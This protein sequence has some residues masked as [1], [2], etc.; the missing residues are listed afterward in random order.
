MMLVKLIAVTVKARFLIWASTQGGNA[1]SCC[2]KP[3]VIVAH[4]AFDRDAGLECGL[5][6]ASQAH[7]DMISFAFDIRRFHVL[8]ERVDTSA[9]VRSKPFWQVFFALHF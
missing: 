3:Y 8:G 5:R 2:R 9:V 7:L 6:T 1:L 4:T